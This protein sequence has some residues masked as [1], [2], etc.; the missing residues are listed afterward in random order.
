MVA[1]RG[2]FDGKVIIPDEPLNL[3]VN[4]R[5]LFSVVPEMQLPPGLSGAEL[6]DALKQVNIPQEDLDRM[7]KAIEESCE[8]IDDDQDV[9]P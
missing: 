8:R 5:L 1:M 7:E 3:P 6:L 4:Q 9:R 2:H